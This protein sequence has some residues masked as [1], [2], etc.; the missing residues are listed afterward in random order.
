MKKLGFDFD[1]LLVDKPLRHPVRSFLTVLF[2]LLDHAPNLTNKELSAF[3]YIQILTTEAV[4][5]HKAKDRELLCQ[6]NELDLLVTT[7]FFDRIKHTSQ[8]TS[9]FLIIY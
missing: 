7:I 5:T 4:L 8:M 1:G 2:G 6:M 3:E 9:N